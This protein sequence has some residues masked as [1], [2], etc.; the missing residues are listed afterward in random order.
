MGANILP[1]S[2]LPEL[3]T[4]VC[5]LSN[6]AIHHYRQ[7]QAEAQICSSGQ[8]SVTSSSK[9]RTICKHAKEK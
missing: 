7:I 5:Q 1:D 3:V 4:Y 9:L 8:K 6:D 2:G